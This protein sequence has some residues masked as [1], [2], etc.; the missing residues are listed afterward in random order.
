MNAVTNAPSDRG[1]DGVARLCAWRM[2]TE[3]D[4]PLSLDEGEGHFPVIVWRGH[5]VLDTADLWHKRR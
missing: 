4:E 5:T 3:A 2:V 1:T